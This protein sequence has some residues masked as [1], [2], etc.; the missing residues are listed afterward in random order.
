[1]GHERDEYRIKVNGD[2]HVYESRAIAAEK[3]VAEMGEKLDRAYG[4]EMN[5]IMGME[6]YGD[7]LTEALAMLKES[8]PVAFDYEYSTLHCNKCHREV[9]LPHFDTCAYAALIER[10]EEAQ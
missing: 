6:Y 7:L 5:A 2:W 8:F 10:I 4:E 1:M 3:R 9:S